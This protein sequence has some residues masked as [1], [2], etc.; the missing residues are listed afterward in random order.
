MILILLALIV[1][2]SAGSDYFAVKIESEY[3][4]YKIFTK[5]SEC[6]GAVYY[7][8]EDKRVLFQDEVWKIGTLKND[9]DCNTL[10]SV[11]KED[12]RTKEKQIPRDG[13]WIDIKYTESHG[14][15]THYFQQQI[16]IK[17]FNKR[18]ESP[19]LKLV[20]GTNVDAKSREVCLRKAFWVNFSP[21]KDIV[22]AFQQ[23]NCFYDFVDE[24]ELE[25]ETL[26][27]TIFVYP[28][29]KNEIRFY[30]F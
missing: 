8:S 16:F 21:D 26:R 29:G 13:W 12:Y 22:L 2:S 23:S 9:L 24:A 6:K 5:I 27:A 15:N 3:E 25:E 14:N 20:N 4:N 30:D 18:V 28:A 7:Q 17:G 10:S 1:P 19:G 11:V